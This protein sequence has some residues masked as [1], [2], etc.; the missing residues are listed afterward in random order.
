M[1]SPR[2][3]P[4]PRA[5]PHSAGIHVGNE[6]T[7]PVGGSSTA[8]QNATHGV[9]TVGNAVF[10]GYVLALF[11]SLTLMALVTFALITFLRNPRSRSPATYEALSVGERSPRIEG[12]R[13]EGVAKLL[14]EALL[15][16]RRISGCRICTP[17]ELCTE[18]ETRCSLKTFVEVYHAVVYGGL[19]SEKVD[20]A[21][22]EA[23]RCLEK[24]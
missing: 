4:L 2:Y 23:K 20:E 22:R 5:P 1:P 10:P 9:V 16:L 21:L 24:P 6:G 8:L 18:L 7:M 15:A 13:Y 14:R 11:I 3:I 12:Y 19:R 17:L